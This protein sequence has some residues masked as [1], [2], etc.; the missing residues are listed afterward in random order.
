[1]MREQNG[2][3]TVYMAMCLGIIL[4]LCLTLIDG[5]RRNGAALEAACVTDIGMQSILAEYHRQ[6]LEQYNLFALDSSYGTA[7]YGSY[8]TEAHLLGYLEKNIILDDVLAS[9][10]FYRDFLALQIEG[11][12]MTGMSIL[13]DGGGAVFRRRASEAVQDDVLLSALEEIR[14]WTEVVSINGLDGA[15]T[16]EE[17]QTLDRRLREYEYEDEEGQMQ[18]GV[19]N[20]TSVLEEIRSLGILRL[21]LEDDSQVSQNTLDL[22]GLVYSRMKQGKVSR[23]NLPLAAALWTEDLAERFFFQEYLLRYM[24]R[25]GKLD[26]RDALCYQIEYL[27]AGNE[28]D[29]DNLRSVANRLCTL[30]EAANA[31]YLWSDSEKMQEVKAA[32]G[33]I[34]AIVL[35]PQLAPVLEAAIVL[36]W[37]YAESVYDVKSL[38]SGGR[39]P[40]MKDKS[41]WHYSLQNALS[42]GLGEYTEEGKGL[43]YED[44]LRIFLW[45]TNLE[46]LTGRAMDMVEADMRMT[47]GNENFCLDGCYDRVEFDIRMSSGFGY[48]FQLVRGRG[49]S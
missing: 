13:T 10:F 23:G 27:I 16:K 14:E 34:S 33:L 6:L 25:Y 38:L 11:V 20:P 24:G 8:N 48:E 43:T 45:L 1:M 2:Y 36:G 26:E 12:E 21:V 15:D 19:E 17:K 9:A 40:L 39:I 47:S 32:A 42:G 3:L 28:N 49:Y 4:S 7:S 35:Q 44:Y 31:M 5:V 22:T 30:R 37:A 46:D 41:S 18:T 29:T